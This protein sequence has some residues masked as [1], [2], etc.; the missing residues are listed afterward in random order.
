[1]TLRHWSF[2][3][4]I[5]FEGHPRGAYAASQRDAQEGRALLVSLSLG[6]GTIGRSFPPRKTAENGRPGELLDNMRAKGDDGDGP[7]AEVGRSDKRVNGGSQ[8]D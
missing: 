8:K 5:I 1:M 6:C 2:V 3:T 4:Q 7:G